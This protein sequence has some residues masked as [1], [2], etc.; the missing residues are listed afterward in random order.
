MT[1]FDG[2]MADLPDLHRRINLNKLAVPAIQVIYDV[3]FGQPRCNVIKEVMLRP[4]A[5]KAKP[6]LDTE[7]HQERP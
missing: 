7:K 1:E 4:G 2:L 6:V 3:S 5:H